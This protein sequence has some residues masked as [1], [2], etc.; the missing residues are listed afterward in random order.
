MRE[1]R[2]RAELIVTY[3]GAQ[4]R[5]C[6]LLGRKVADAFGYE[7]PFFTAAIEP[8]TAAWPEPITLVSLPHRPAA[9]RRCGPTARGSGRAT[10]CAS[11]CPASRG[12]R[13]D[14]PGTP[15]GR[16]RA[17]PPRVGFGHL[18]A[19]RGF[20]VRW[21]SHGRRA[22]HRGRGAP[23]GRRARSDRRARARTR[24]RLA[25]VDGRRGPAAARLRLVREGGARRRHRRVDAYGQAERFDLDGQC[26]GTRCRAST[27][28][29][30]SGLN[31]LEAMRGRH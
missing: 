5:V 8:L 28:R 23:R 24:D 21:R 1:A 27:T 31:D 10:S 4:L 11:S 14:G 25:R 26:R 13:C 6:V 7:L 29:S 17:D 19:W 18:P 30:C 12:G 2:R 15:L 16:A 22:E 20:R 3:P 9:T